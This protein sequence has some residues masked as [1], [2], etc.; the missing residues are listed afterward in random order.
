M[1]FQKLSE[2][3]MLLTPMAIAFALCLPGLILLRKKVKT[4]FSEYFIVP[5]TAAIYVITIYLFNAG[6]K[7]LGNLVE[8]IFVLPIFMVVSFYLKELFCFLKPQKNFAPS[9]IL[10]AVNL[11]FAISIAMLVPPLVE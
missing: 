5:L 11:L 8:V 7:T 4:H 2:L 6:G 1:S 3:L 10:L 9:F